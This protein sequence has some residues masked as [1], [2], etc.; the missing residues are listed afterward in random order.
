MDIINPPMVPAESGNQNPSF[1]LPTMKGINPNMV[2]TT[3]R[4]IGNT[5]LFHAFIY[6]FPGEREGNCLRMALYSLMI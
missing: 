1:S 4:K 3:V 2:D 5:F 6:D